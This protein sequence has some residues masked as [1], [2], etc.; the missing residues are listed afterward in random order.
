M[1]E[2]DAVFAVAEELFAG[3]FDMVIFMTGVGTRALDAL[4]TTR[5]PKERFPEA[6]R[7]LTV[8]ARGPK[9]AAALRE[10]GLEPD[11]TAPEP[12]T[13]REILAAID[14]RPERRVAVQEYGRSN[15]ELLK[16]LRQRGAEVTPIRIYSWDL[17][18]DAGPCGRR[19]GNWLP[20]VSTYWC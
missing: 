17:P 19:S 13:W 2:N 7:R 11:I 15:P 14:G 5:Y 18:E 9:P 16:A 20:V 8:V 4:L 12:N 3:R 6:L 10:L 1:S